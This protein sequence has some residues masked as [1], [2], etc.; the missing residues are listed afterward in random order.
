VACGAQQTSDRQ[1]RSG[2]SRVTPARQA[3]HSQEQAVNAPR[4]RNFL[5][6]GYP[7][8]QRMKFLPFCFFLLLLPGL[9]A[10]HVI[11]L[12]N[13]SFEDF[14][15]VGKAPR[16][17]TDCGPA[18][19]TPPDVHP[20]Q[21]LSNAFWGVTTPAYHG[22]TYLGLVVRDNVTTEAVGQKLSS[23]LTPGYTY[24]LDV[25]VARSSV[26]DARSLVS[27]EIVPHTDPA[28]LRVWGGNR[29]CTFEKLLAES[30]PIESTDWETISLLFNADEKY[31]YLILEAYYVPGA[32][33]YYCGHVL[34]DNC[35]DL[36][37][38]APLSDISS[39]QEKAQWEELILDGYSFFLGR[40]QN[41][42]QDLPEELSILCH[43]SALLDK[44]NEGVQE[45]LIRSSQAEILEA[46]KSLEALDMLSV[47]QVLEEGLG[48]HETPREE[49][50]LETELA[51]EALDASFSEAIQSDGFDV[52]RKAYLEN[53]W[54]VVVTQ[55]KELLGLRKTK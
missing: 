17:W 8:Y 29:S 37:G 52:K 14:A 41:P 30:A 51:W 38:Y 47:A 24:R 19:M 21:N 53:H 49:W 28:V 33:K 6:L 11:E 18:D 16:G 55:V 12:T 31:S 32:L 40:E 54:E 22:D 2:T 45:Y 23:R 5:F 46:Q 35:S 20:A 44:T 39:T 25:Q 1:R 15:R 7:N 27:N 50:T 34:L 26:F 36:V 42:W 9:E 3:G 4:K 48:I 43:L 13:P 10:Q